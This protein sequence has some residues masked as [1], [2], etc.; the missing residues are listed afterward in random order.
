MSSKLADATTVMK[1]AH[2]YPRLLGDV[3]GTNARFGWQSHGHAGL[4]FIRTLPCASSTSLADA[5]K[6][7]L[8][9][10]GLPQPAAA[11]IG[12]AT[13]ITGDMVNMTNHHWSFSIRELQQQ[14]SLE[15]LHVINDFTALALALPDLRDDQK[16]RIGKACETMPRQP[17]ALI[18]AGTGLGVSGLLPTGNTGWAPISGEGGHVTLAAG[19][20]EE[21]EVITHLRNR[22]SH[23][24]AERVLSGQGL[25]DLHEALCTVRGR[26]WKPTSLAVEISNKALIHADEDCL[27]TMNMFA[28]LL[29]SV[30]GDLALTLGARG[31]VYIGGGIVPRWLGWFEQ[32]P[33]RYRF[34]HKGRFSDYLKAIPTWVISADDPPALWGAARALDNL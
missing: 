23:A 13:A 26:P 11:C 7:Y 18:G 28:G 2:L 22:Y 30:A 4:E 10:G 12:I 33:F 15:Y 24:S 9:L 16:I 6:Q 19:N 5:I 34:E 25:L 31:G 21:F 29:G 32:S 3:G 14:L 17:I 1:P 20:E 27:A 8:Q